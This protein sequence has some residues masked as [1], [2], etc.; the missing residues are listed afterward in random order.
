VRWS[1]TS[2]AS[3]AVLERLVRGFLC[4]VLVVGVC[5]V[6]ASCA[7]GTPTAG[8]APAGVAA[9]VGRLPPAADA[10]AA[11]EVA[12][13]L[14]V[15]DCVK[16][17]SSTT[18]EE[19]FAGLLL[20]T[21][22]AQPDDPGTMRRVLNA[23]GMKFLYRLLASPGSPDGA[24]DSSL[25]Y[26]CMALNVVS[27]F[28]ALHEL[29]PDMHEQKDFMRMAPLLVKALDTIAGVMHPAIDS[30]LVC[31][32]CMAASDA[33]TRAL[34]THRGP[35]AVADFLQHLNDADSERK[36]R[37][38][39]VLDSLL[40]PADFPAA[41]AEAVLSIAHVLADG[42]GLVR[43]DLLPRMALTLRS[44]N[45]VFLAKLHAL[46]V[47]WHSTLRN[48]LQNLLQNKLPSRYRKHILS[49]ALA[50]CEHFGQ[51]WAL[52]PARAGETCPDGTFVQL[53]VGFSNIEL[54]LRL[55]EAEK[56]ADNVEV[57]PVALA[58]VEKTL[59][60][61]SEDA[62]EPDSGGREEGTG[63]QGAGILAQRWV[64]MDVERLLKMKRDL[65]EAVEAV[66][67]YLQDLHE[68]ANF[69]DALV[70]PMARLLGLWFLEVDSD[71]FRAKLCAALE[72]LVR[73]RCAQ[74]VGVLGGV[75]S[76]EQ[77][78]QVPLYFLLPALTHMMEVDDVRRCFVRAHGHVAAAEIVVAALEGKG[79]RGPGSE[80]ARETGEHGASDVCMAG[81]LLLTRI[82]ALQP[83][84]RVLVRVGFV[85][86]PAV[87]GSG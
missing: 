40:T 43:L 28:C 19:K 20:V 71:D 24:D 30:V 84:V 10:A 62:D 15:D 64:S 60:F 25:M 32:A 59:M 83:Q 44:R 86:V 78:Q 85:L 4:L 8:V 9:G 61:L 56:P 51:A 16:L 49:A 63:T 17:L 2:S 27:S 35:A 39:F 67:I 53:I 80:E 68:G 79:R 74:D 7:M 14:Q 57:V 11:G 55:E 76:T 37:A 72:V 45:A 73:T 66:F 70:L 48:A 69:G 54:R 18:D 34:C 31:L 26:Q 23:V 21:K 41:T 38:L 5:V 6:P 1:E 36:S 58:L 33:G 65:E 13:G 46:G 77:V 47:A 81:V 12:K 52:H 75:T 50:M 82:V 22:V 87:L 29:W 3:A 42:K